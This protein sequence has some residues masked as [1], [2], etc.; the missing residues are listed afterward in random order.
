MEDS[1]SKLYKI[2]WVPETEKVIWDM[3]TEEPISINDMIYKRVTNHLNLTKWIKFYKGL[4]SDWLEDDKNDVYDITHDIN[5]MAINAL[6]KIN[7]SLN[8]IKL[9]YWFDKDRTEEENFQ[10]E[11]CPLTNQKLIYLG[12]EYHYLNRYI[13]PNS[14]LVFPEN[15]EYSK[16]LEINK[17]LELSI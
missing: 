7:Q 3:R 6:G 14:F 10:W 17:I 4:Y 1:R 11:F 9:Y 16:E 15:L 13:S 8:E 2:M 5:Q 12:K